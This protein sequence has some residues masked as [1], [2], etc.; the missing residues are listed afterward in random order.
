MRLSIPIPRLPF[1]P[2]PFRRVAVPRSLEE[3]TSAGE[4]VHPLEVGMDGDG[5]ARIWRAVEGIY[6]SGVHPAIQLCL[7]RDGQVVMDRAIGHARSNGPNDGPEVERVPV[8]TE[9]PFVIYSA[10]KAV[11]AMVVHLLDQRGELHI[12]DRVCEYI[13]EYARHGKHTVTISHVLAHRAGVPNIPQE[14]FD[15]DLIDDR[16]AILAMLCDA[17]P[18][19]RPG[20]SL[21]YHAVSGGFII[22]ELVQRVTG[23][24]IRAVMATEVLEPLGFR[25]MNYGVAEEDVPAVGRNYVTG[26]PP[27]PGLSHL[28]KR[29]LG[30]S[31][32]RVVELSNDPRFLTGVIPSANVVTNARELARWY[33][34]LRR[35]GEL[36]GV[37]VYEPR[38]IRRATIEQSYL[39]IDWTLG[40]PFRYSTGFMLGARVLSLYG[41]DTESAFGHLGFTNIFGWAD[42][43]RA[44]AGA[45]I[46]SGNPVLY[47]ELP[48]LWNL[49]RTIGREAP[50]VPQATLA[51]GAS[52]GLS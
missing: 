25:W 46:T 6:R 50:K 48:D 42:P 49:M 45:L 41:L 2:D 7:M 47:P 20:K 34:L 15:L 4:E 24:D 13:P 52:P 29:A 39:E 14:A 8:D 17:R 43:D 9:T 3:V 32:E 12:D 1:V 51:P 44:L 33:E 28:L 19:A 11:T 38:T 35:G 26:A 21:S 36:D 37:Q 27:P 5:V 31:V 10:S 30:V 18:R 16:E 23:K 40:F 22:G